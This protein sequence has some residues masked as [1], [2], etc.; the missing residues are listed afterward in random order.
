[1]PTRVRKPTAG[2]G[3]E[4]LPD[5]YSTRADFNQSSL[6]LHQLQEPDEDAAT[7]AGGSQ[8]PGGSQGAPAQVEPTRAVD[9][10]YEDIRSISRGAPMCSVHL[11]CLR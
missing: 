4:L 2:G 11:P 9:I 8:Q 10:N 6:T 3:W 1:M 7:S 5:A